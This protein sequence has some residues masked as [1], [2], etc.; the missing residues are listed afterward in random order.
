[1]MELKNKFKD[2]SQFEDPSFL[3]ECKRRFFNTEANWR[4]ILEGNE[5]ACNKLGNALLSKILG[6]SYSLQWKVPLMPSSPEPITDMM[7][8]EIPENQI[9]S[10]FDRCFNELKVNFLEAT[11]PSGE[12]WIIDWQAASVLYSGKELK[13]AKT[14]IDQTQ[15][16]KRLFKDQNFEL[17]IVRGGT[18]SEKIF[19]HSPIW[20]CIE[21]VGK[22][23]RQ[24]I[25]RQI[26]AAW[27]T[28]ITPANKKI[29]AGLHLNDALLSD[30]ALWMNLQNSS[31]IRFCDL[32]TGREL[33]HSKD[34]KISHRQT[35]K[36]FYLLEHSEGEKTQLSRFE[37]LEQINGWVEAN[38]DESAPRDAFLDFNR[39]RSAEGNNPLSF[40]FDDT[41]HRW[42]YS[43]D[44]SF[45]I[46]TEDDTYLQLR[47]NHF[48]RLTTEG[49]K[50]KKQKILIA[51]SEISS[52]GYSPLVQIAIPP[53]QNN[54]GEVLDGQKGMLKYFEY[55]IDKQGA[56][57]P[58]SFDSTI[59][60]AHLYLAQK[61][62]DAANAII[63]S[64]SSTE[65]VS[66]HILQMIDKL[67]CS[68]QLLSD[69]S[70][71]AAALHLQVYLMLLRVAPLLKLEE[72]PM[73]ALAK[74]YGIY[75][76]GL[77]SVEHS[78]VLTNEEE[79]LLLDSL[80]YDE[81]QWRRD[82]LLGK[83][84]SYKKVPRV[85][86]AGKMVLRLLP[87]DERSQN[88]HAAIY[89]D[90]LF[91]SSNFSEFK[92]YY[93]KLKEVGS[94]DSIALKGVIY[95]I[96]FNLKHR[97][98]SFTP[99]QRNVLAW[100]ASNPQ[101]APL[102]PECLDEIYSISSSGSFPSNS[103]KEEVRSWYKKF[104][105]SQIVSEEKPSDINFKWSSISYLN[106]DYN[107]VATHQKS[108]IT[109]N[110]KQIQ[111]NFREGLT[112][113]EIGQ[114]AAYE[115]WQ[116]EYLTTTKSNHSLSDDH[117]GEERSE[118]QDVGAELA[119]YADAIDRHQQHY[120]TDCQ[121][122]RNK[123][124]EAL[125]F[126]S[127]LS[128]D[129]YRLL[130]EEMTIEEN[131]CK[132]SESELLKNIH[133]LIAKGQVW[134][135]DN[136]N[137]HYALS[138]VQSQGF[139]KP[140]PTLTSI[141]RAASQINGEQ[142]LAILNPYLSDEEILHLRSI[143]VE[144]ML[145]VTH[146]QH[147]QRVSIPL[148]SW[149]HSAETDPSAASLFHNAQEA[150]IQARS[151]NPTKSF[152]SLLFE[153]LSDI[154][155][156]GKQ[157]DIIDRVLRVINEE[158]NEE[159]KKIAF[160][161]IMAGGKTSVIISM[162]V[163]LIASSG[164]LAC[165]MCH[166]S[167]LASVKGNLSYFQRSRFDK[168]LFVIDYSMEQLKDIKILDLIIK[169]LNKAKKK[170]IAL[171]MKTSFS[172]LIELKFILELQRLSDSDHSADAR[173]LHQQTV[174]KLG[175]I[176]QI[177]SSS[178]LA[179][180]DECDINLSIMTDVNIPLGHI[181]RLEPEHIDL[182]K[183]IYLKLITPQMKD[184]IG[185]DKNLQAELSIDHLNREVIP[186]IANGIF[187]SFTI[188]E[189]WKE[190]FLRYVTEE[191]SSEDQKKADQ[192]ALLS[193]HERE[194]FDLSENSA[195]LVE[196]KRLYHSASPREKQSAQL[197]ALTRQILCT[198][199][200][201]SL[202][203]TYN[204]NYGRE[205]NCNDGRVCPYL[206]AGT[207]ATTKFGSVYMLLA[208][209]FQSSL[210]GGISEEQIIFLA[211]KMKEA[212]Q[213][214]APKENIHF[215]ETAEAQQFKFLT[216]LD[217]FEIFKEGGV[218]KA[219][220][221]VNDPNNLE[222]RLNFEAETVPFHIQYHTDR[223]SSN[224]INNVSRFKAKGSVACSGT[225]WNQPTYHQDFRSPYLDSGT[226]GTILN[227]M[228]ERDTVINEIPDRNLENFLS[229]IDGH[230]DKKRVRAI[231]DGGGFFQGITNALLAEKLKEF[232]QNNEAPLH[233]V[234]YV[235][236]FSEEEVSQ[237]FPKESFTFLRLDGKKSLPVLLK[238]TSSEELAK[239]GLTKDDIFVFFD[240][241]RA[242][243]T[244]IELA[245][246]AI[247]LTTID[248]KMLMRTELQQ[249]LR[250]R[251]FFNKQEV[252]IV[253]TSNGRNQMVN[254]G[255]TFVD[256][257]E[258]LI[259]NEAI[260]LQDQTQ[261]SRIAQLDNIVRSALIQDLLKSHSSSQQEKIKNYIH[262]FVSKTEDDPYLNSG[263]IR[264]KSPAKRALLE[265]SN[266]L[267][268]KL[269]SLHLEDGE[270]VTRALDELTTHLIE[271]I[272]D[273]EYMNDLDT[274][275]IEAEV[276]QENQVEMALA[277]EE[278][279]TVEVNQE[280]M[281]ELHEYSCGET[282]VPFKEKDWHL[283]C[284]RS[285]WEQMKEHLIGVK[286]TLGRTDFNRPFSEKM[287]EYGN[288]F[289]GHLTMTSNFY[290]TTT[291]ELPLLSSYIKEAQFCLAIKEGETHAYQYVLVSEKEAAFFKNWLST[292][293]RG[294][295]CLVDLN[296]FQEGG[297]LNEVFD[298]EEALQSLEEGLCYANLFNGDISYLEEHPK[299]AEKVIPED[300]ELLMHFI[301]LKV[302]SS[303]GVAALNKLITSKLFDFRTITTAKSVAGIMCSFR[304]QQSNRR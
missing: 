295:A 134:T 226:E 297:R 153:Y 102:W 291:E 8:N 35:G 203:R 147:I 94:A 100:T 56:I 75:V 138:Q 208:Y 38:K 29:K 166:H 193:A 245:D 96:L 264:G 293:H 53:S 88:P 254:G 290:R 221:Y 131:R 292:H 149:I 183:N 219:H 227:R 284:N 304:R 87:S 188:D 61:K 253:V 18:P 101:E 181:K 114:D 163:E 151:Y 99:L 20:G 81:S 135:D 263:K 243:G 213:Y 70:P 120:I 198:V 265:Y 34:G 72:K 49:E 272:S 204:R 248:N 168:D 214:F 259:K 43:E 78:L 76:N 12:K 195:F 7:N 288:C 200:K 301:Q 80:E 162:L 30:H 170:G 274:G 281:S 93:F 179:I 275:N 172:D 194:S 225:L 105:E 137:L 273:N 107:P 67:I 55:S 228:K 242:T 83:N 47:L 299:M 130:I 110:K 233:A 28:Y 235:H 190:P 199:L 4:M 1:M 282:L 37:S 155:I 39:L 205:L 217:L 176:H 77:N 280:L 143:A 287:K 141:L 289:P 230:A 210:A 146:R 255:K 74:D 132:K 189:Q 125:A 241:S 215:L 180:Y 186:S 279:K 239:H 258:T 51:Q 234:V 13:G 63:R 116:K 90:P 148:S 261:R 246:N 303:K 113:V 211:E 106:H 231:V 123:R 251:K 9:Q 85:D 16:V 300:P 111:M 171:V 48:L 36:I 164:S 21:I 269:T 19:F 45:Y 286:E 73:I 229:M 27:Y 97:D 79:L 42:I 298:T 144:Y 17:N 50:E 41:H 6:S 278:E 31:D 159:L 236:K 59:Y 98:L 86:G 267:K 82:H 250:A 124:E 71:N 156:R 103:Q 222:R 257:Q 62:Y 117:D 5:Q 276:F 169:Q 119:Y 133:S 109:Q 118:I 160:Q 260:A 196:L 207:P 247:F 154:R 44:P 224:S 216:G 15:A 262:F 201:I 54:K 58:H 237:G 142:E 165:V 104:N 244:D 40:K 128:K 84:Y 139:F 256:I 283:D 174:A 60:L 238:N 161:L 206:A 220:T 173:N 66:P 271:E 182:M 187:S 157:A 175:E 178:A 209:Q 294:H 145:E 232:L 296:G 57:I 52:R 11:D 95:E 223:I 115:R 140:R 112:W 167:Q 240:E 108:L 32:E 26:D 177:L 126:K 158:K 33:Y 266:S 10:V 127:D 150:F 212:S 92:K 64:I 136:S 23:E 122:A 24:Q 22:G 252:E 152:F 218:K 121:V 65:T 25:L 285:L 268:Q 3:K 91:R 68:S 192:Y 270:D 89:I 46:D 185:L 202:S 191:I 2:V 129:Q 14:K 249:T 69:F 302:L 277:V 197:I 184:L